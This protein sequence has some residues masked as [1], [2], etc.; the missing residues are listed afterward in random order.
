MVL[1]TDVYRNLTSLWIKPRDRAFK[2][3]KSPVLNVLTWP[4]LWSS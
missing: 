4:A 2:Q 3:F 1:L